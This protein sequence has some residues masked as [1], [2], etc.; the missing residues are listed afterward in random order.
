MKSTIEF[1]NVIINQ[2]EVDR[3]EFRLKGQE[4][5]VRFL[6][7]EWLNCL[8]KINNKENWGLNCLL[9]TY[10]ELIEI[11]QS[12]YHW[13]KEY[14]ERWFI[15]DDDEKDNEG[16]YVLC[17]SEACIEVEKGDYWL[18]HVKNDYAMVL[19]DLDQLNRKIYELEKEV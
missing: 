4:S 19:H 11:L 10:D 2:D 7:D 6:E 12:Q 13:L 5:K 1:H 8:H 9:F 18:V 15:L 14:I 16:N 3:L 17:F